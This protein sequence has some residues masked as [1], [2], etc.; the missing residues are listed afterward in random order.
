MIIIAK[1]YIEYN[2]NINN[3]FFDS[4]MSVIK[5]ACCFPSI[6]KFDQINLASCPSESYFGEEE[7][8]FD[9]FCFGFSIFR[10]V[11]R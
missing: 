9:E 6:D 1:V 7:W 11:M 2:F 10:K 5:A 8:G 3:N 4:N